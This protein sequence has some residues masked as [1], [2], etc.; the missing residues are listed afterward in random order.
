[1][2]L[3]F[4]HSVKPDTCDDDRSPSLNKRDELLMHLEELEIRTTALCETCLTTRTMHRDAMI[5]EG[6]VT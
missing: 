3:P 2:P 6:A 1:M 4:P 5:L